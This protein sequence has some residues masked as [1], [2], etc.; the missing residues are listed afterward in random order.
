MIFYQV[1]AEVQNLPWVYLN[2]FL[3][4]L[5]FSSKRISYFDCMNLFLSIVIS[6]L[7]KSSKNSIVDFLIRKRL[8]DSQSIIP[9]LNKKL[10]YLHQS[11][12]YLK[13]ILKVN[14][15]TLVWFHI[16]IELVEHI[17][18]PGIESRTIVTLALPKTY[19]I[20]TGPCIMFYLQKVD[21]SH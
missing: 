15:R 2:S 7:E 9:I 18:T 8:K 13:K 6:F 11:K 12:F 3:S 4:F 10:I 16:V 20:F 21:L 17:I 19:K 1:L 14:T 5:L